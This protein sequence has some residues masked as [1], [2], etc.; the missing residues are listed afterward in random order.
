MP[1]VLPK[2]DIDAADAAVA[3]AQ[4]VRKFH[5]RRT[6]RTDPR[7]KEDIALARERLREA[8]APLKSE[9]GRFAYGPQTAI[10]EQN[11]QAIRDASAR[12]QTERRKLSKMG[13]A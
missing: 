9:I 7:R 13:S 6:G 2:D 10:A 3:F 5:R 11:R 1:N 12:I 4:Q 8:M